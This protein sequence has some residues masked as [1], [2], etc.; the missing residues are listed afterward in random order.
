MQTSKEIYQRIL[1][2]LN[3]EKSRISSIHEQALQRSELLKLCSETSQGFDPA[4]GVNIKMAL[5]FAVLANNYTITDLMEYIRVTLEDPFDAKFYKTEN[6]DAFDAKFGTKTALI[7]E[8]FALP[9]KISIDRFKNSGRYIPTPINTMKVALEGAGRYMDFHE[10]YFIDVGSGLGRNLLLASEYPFKKIIGIEI[11]EFLTTQAKSN[12]QRY[13]SPNTGCKEVEAICVDALKYTFPNHDIFIYMW[14]PFNEQ[15]FEVFFANLI[16]HAS[17]FG[18]RIF[19]AI[20]GQKY[21]RSRALQSFKYLGALRTPGLID[22][23]ARDY[24]TVNLYANYPIG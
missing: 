6:E 11:S 17:K 7:Y 9:E 23:F 21:S 5:D 15:V 13:R 3:D 10:F 14:E 16:A 12:I 19:F 24:L 20:L 1:E 4:V 8:Q 18:N 22:G 2:R